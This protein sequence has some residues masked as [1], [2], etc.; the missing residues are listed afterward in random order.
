VLFEMQRHD[1]QELLE[2]IVKRP[3]HL[4]ARLVLGERQ[5]PRHLPQLR[6]PV[7][8]FGRAFLE[9]RRGTLAVGDVGDERERAP[10]ASSRH[11]IDG[12]FDRKRGPV[13]ACAHESHT[14]RGGGTVAKERWYQAL[15]RLADQR[16]GGPA[17]HYL[18]RTI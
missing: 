4:V 15:D 13:P 10:A 17:E 18:H 2:A 11:F 1:D 8:Q 9:G 16:F 12:D 6:R 14:S 7:F 3:G 5:V